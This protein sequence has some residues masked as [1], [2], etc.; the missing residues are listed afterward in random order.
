MSTRS[1]DAASALTELYSELGSSRRSASL[2]PNLGEKRI[3]ERNARAKRYIYDRQR[4]AAIK[5]RLARIAERGDSRDER[6]K[7]LLLLGWRQ[8]SPASAASAASTRSRSASVASTRSRWASSSYCSLS[9]KQRHKV[10]IRAKAELC[11]GIGTPTQIVPVCKNGRVRSCRELELSEK[12]KLARQPRHLIPLGYRKNVRNAKEAIREA[13]REANAREMIRHQERNARLQ[14][15]IVARCTKPRRI[16]KDR[17][18]DAK[19][20]AL[21]PR[22]YDRETA[23][24]I[25]DRT[26]ITQCQGTCY[27]VSVMILLTKLKMIYDLLHWQ[28]Q[29]YVDTINTCPRIDAKRCTL[30]PQKV[31]KLF[32]MLDPGQPGASL[33]A[34]NRS[35][36]YAKGGWPGLLLKAIL[37]HSD[38]PFAWSNEHRFVMR[39]DD[40]IAERVYDWLYVCVA[41]APA[42]KDTPL[43]LKGVNTR[44]EKWRGLPSSF[45][46][47]VK[48]QTQVRHPGI[49]DGSPN[50]PNSP[51][52]KSPELKRPP[53]LRRAAF[54]IIEIKINSIVASGPHPQLHSNDDPPQVYQRA[55]RRMAA[56][57]HEREQRA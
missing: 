1:R 37:L 20:C 7:P 27:F 54:S 39:W 32:V 4:S 10:S 5:A 31:R 8:V 19:H 14:K 35:A 57:E 30:A 50:S 3:Q 56:R 22:N 40:R 46:S 42:V 6:E 24:S 33:S 17:R 36:T 48:N 2:P 11:K 18:W 21:I 34:A 38:I 12:Y 47:F 45:F 52:S 25:C 23:S 16:A 9:A 55:L 43:W 41:E 26:G 29:K 15:E 51:L 49:P 44:V 53:P 28:T 13:K